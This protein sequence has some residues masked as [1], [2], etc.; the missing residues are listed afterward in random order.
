MFT[1]CTTDR[2]AQRK[3]FGETTCKKIKEEKA[4]REGSNE[5][6]IAWIHDSADPDKN[7]CDIY[8]AHL[9][10]LLSILLWKSVPTVD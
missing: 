9:C 10:S 7:S 4:A 8:K 6:K 1:C 2:V 3:P 5:N